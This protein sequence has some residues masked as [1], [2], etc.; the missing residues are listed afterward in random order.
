[1]ENDLLLIGLT[2]LKFLF[3]SSFL[4]NVFGLKHKDPKINLNAPTTFFLRTLPSSFLST[5]ST[6]M[7]PS[8]IF[9]QDVLR[10]RARE[11]YLVRYCSVTTNS[12][13]SVFTARTVDHRSMVAAL[14]HA[15]STV[16][17][18][19]TGRRRASPWWPHGGGT[20]GL[21]LVGFAF[22]SRW[23]ACFLV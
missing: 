1:M 15:G 14:L 7:I 12:Y 23:L 2:L 6:S 4:Y 8:A 22:Y 16:E 10:M 17:L 9:A 11:E 18:G 3:F 21:T 19:A 20:N 13:A 5:L